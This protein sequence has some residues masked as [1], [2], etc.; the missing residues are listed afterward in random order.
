MKRINSSI[1][2]YIQNTVYS[3]SKYASIYTVKQ[4]TN[5]LNHTLFYQ[6]KTLQNNKSLYEYNIN[7][8]STIET[9]IEQ[10]GGSSSISI[11]LYII[12][13]FLYILFLWSGLPSIISKILSISLRKS[14]NFVTNKLLGKGYRASFVRNIIHIIILFFTFFSIYFFI[15]YTVFYMSFAIFYIYKGNDF[16][17]AGETSKDIA[18]IVTKWFISIYVFINMFNYF[19]DSVIFAVGYTE[20][21]IVQGSAIAILDV[22]ERGWNKFKYFPVYIIP[23]IGNRFQILHKETPPRING[24]YSFLDNANKKRCSTKPEKNM[25]T[26][27]DLYNSQVVYVHKDTKYIDRITSIFGKKSNTQ[28]IKT[29]YSTFTTMSLVGSIIE[30]YS[31]EHPNDV[32]KQQDSIKTELEKYN[33]NPTIQKYINGHFV[34][35][36]RNIALTISKIACQII[37]LLSEMNNDLLEMGERHQVVNMVQS[38]QLAGFISSFV[39]I[40]YVIYY[41]FTT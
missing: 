15:K 10:K 32:K 23:W 31:N 28:V 13:F 21:E 4:K 9:T 22:I 38:S 2:V 24:L 33:A 27:E 20:P 34:S 16:C 19:L 18:N 26:M 40:G 6:G 14:M 25:K 12:L 3:F 41:S 1:R 8:N 30:Y 37:E 36:N 35:I 7:N 29:R 11:F 5:T 39:F 17:D